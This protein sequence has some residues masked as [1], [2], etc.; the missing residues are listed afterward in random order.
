MYK[1]LVG[2]GNVDY[3][4]AID[5][6]GRSVPIRVF[7]DACRFFPKLSVWAEVGT[8]SSL[9]GGI[10]KTCTFARNR[11]RRTTPLPVTDMGIIVTVNYDIVF[12]SDTRSMINNDVV[13]VPMRLARIF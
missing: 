5:P 13:P 3:T 12:K 7:V 4:Q 8:H 11:Y 10:S 6:D 9:I 1:T 2:I